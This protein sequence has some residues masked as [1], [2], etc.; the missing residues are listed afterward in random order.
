MYAA[1]AAADRAR[2]G[3]LSPQQPQQSSAP[4]EKTAESSHS[5]A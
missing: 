3:A 4:D 2:V 1:L 5:P